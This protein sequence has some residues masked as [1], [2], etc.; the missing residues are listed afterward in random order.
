MTDKE[1]C[2]FELYSYRKFDD[3]WDGE[4][5]NK[6][7][8]E[9]ISDAIDYVNSFS[10]N[11]NFPESWVGANGKA[12]LWWNN[13]NYY[14]EIEFYEH[15][16]AYFVKLKLTDTVYKGLSNV[17]EIDQKLKEIGIDNSCLR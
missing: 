17:T 16:L 11:S 2:I 12:S 4:G 13:E 1:E 9:S 3:N 15:E 8:L 5:A 10:D 7:S 14:V 6:P